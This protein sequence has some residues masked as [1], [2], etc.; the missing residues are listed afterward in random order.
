MAAHPPHR[1]PL[2]PSL[3]RV[4]CLSCFVEDAICPRW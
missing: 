3:P 2:H 1:R 4:C